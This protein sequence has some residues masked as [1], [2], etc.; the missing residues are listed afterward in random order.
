[1]GKLEQR[2]PELAVVGVSSP[3]YPAEGITENLRH[4]VERLRIEHPV[5][6]DVNHEIWDA[7]A[8]T[9]W[10]TIIF[11]SPKGEVLGAHAGEASLESLERVISEI[12]L[13]YYREGSLSREP[14]DLQVR[15]YARPSTQLSFPGKVLA[16]EDHLFI[17]DSGHHRIVIADREG[18]VHDT[19]GCGTPGHVDGGYSIA[20]FHEPQGMALSSDGT[21]YVAD[22]GSHTIR[23]ID[24][25]RRTVA[26]VAGTGEQA[27]RLVRG[28]PARAT[29]ISSPFDVAL[30][31]LTLYIAMAGLHQ[32]WSLDLPSETL[33]V[34]AGTGHEGIRDAHR[35][36]AWLA[37]PMGISLGEG[38]LYIS[39]AETQAIRV[40]D[41]GSGMVETVTGRGLFDFGDL[42]G[43]ADT[44]LLQHNQGVAVDSGIAYVADTYNNKIRVI[45]LATGAVSSPYGSGQSGVLDGPGKNA[46]F[47][48]PGGASLAAGMLYVADTNNH[49]IRAIDIESGHVRTLE[50][51]GLNA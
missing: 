30:D 3:K 35:Q 29:H 32:V 40:S 28:G 18:L 4:A 51:T 5:V 38:R 10:P 22:A 27:R 16:S 6:N 15:T 31:G 45:D 14:I 2:F 12:N 41:L 25:A 42:D 50:I 26:T 17:A 43:P 48:E 39:C 44:A 8:I 9:A 1:L 46:R 20:Q 47:D 13:E 23:A 7:Y 36:Q 21:L 49:L 11:L 19:V 33:S 24:L 34:W 37:Q